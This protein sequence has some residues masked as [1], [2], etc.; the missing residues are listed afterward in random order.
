MAKD[1]PHVEAARRYAENVVKGRVPA[2]KWV[3][4]ACQ[5]HLND[6]AKQRD[7]KFRYRF[8]PKTAEKW[9]KFLELLPH[10]KGKWARSNQLIRLEPWQCF[11]TCVLLGWLR[12]DDGLRRFRKAF[13]EEPRKNAKSTWAAGI[14]LGML[15]IDG[16][17]GAEVYS[18]ATTEKQAW[19]VFRPARLMAQRSP[20]FQSAFDVTVN[21]SNLHILG[22]GSRFEPV[23]GNPGDGA[24]P[25]CAIIDEYH[26]H[27]TD[28]QVDTMET[29]MGAREQPLLLVITTA[30]DNLAG[31]CYALLQEAQKVLEGVWEN[32]EL[33]ALVYTIDDGDD[34]TKEATLR[35]ANPNFGVS[36]DADFLR[37]RQ[38]EAIRN[39]RKAG[40]F[41]TKHLNLWVQ[42]RSAYFDIRRWIE[43]ADPSLKIEKFRGKPCRVGVDL[44]STTDIAAVEIVFEYG[45][46]Y[47][48]FGRYYLPEATIELPENEHYRAW[49]DAGWI[50]QTDGD[51]VDYITIRDDILQIAD[52][53]QL[54]ELAFDP[55]Q[56]MMMMSE[57][58]SKGVAC[59]EVRPTVPNFSPAMKRVDGLIRSRKI[60]HN[61]DPVMLWMWSNVTA[62]TDA[63]DN[64]YPRKERP[65]NKIDG[66]IAHLMVQ[67][68]YSSG[69]AESVYETRGFRVA[70]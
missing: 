27:D 44:A 30:G 50:T 70:G 4:L 31:P 46:G 3:R 62:R 38:T 28:A 37:S 26:E 14:G 52:E 49:R 5:R 7:P 45:A 39:P 51:M 42:S 33:F 12:K 69:P 1:H 2:C 34:W 22:D 23:I 64:V 20:Q 21:A 35:K 58:G 16:E 68:R 15:T 47:A 66:P 11:K 56:A 43:S 48:R 57:L 29:G 17:H 18:G 60:A 6:L 25:S 67:A 59:V 10:T 19:E 24:S 32:D 41:K 55:F 36:V 65:E 53:H 63:K 13:I 61:G 9:C 54:L 8:D 40:V